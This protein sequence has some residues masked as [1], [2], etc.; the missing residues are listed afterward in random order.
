MSLESE[1]EDSD[2][3]D[4]WEEQH[5]TSAV[6]MPL[7]EYVPRYVAT[8]DTLTMACILSQDDLIEVTE[9]RRMFTG[10]EESS[11][12]REASCG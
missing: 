10:F 9:D 4:V 1:V 11:S 8:E 7:P 5:C 6:F 3:D 2:D 12:P